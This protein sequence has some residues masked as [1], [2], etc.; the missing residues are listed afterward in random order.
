MS[1]R[2]IRSKSFN[3]AQMGG[4]FLLKSSFHFWDEQ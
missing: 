4:I 2:L 1:E 3:K